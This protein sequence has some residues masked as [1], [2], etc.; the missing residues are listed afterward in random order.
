MALTFNPFTGKLDFTGSQASAAIGA[1][2]ATGPSGGPTGA[3]GSTGTAGIDGATGAT[4][5]GS[6]GATGATGP[7]ADLSGYVL[8]SGDTMTGKLVAAADLTASKL[9]IGNAIGTPGPTSVA[10]GDIWITNQNKLAWRTNGNTINAAGLSQTNTFSQPQTIGVTSNA[11]PVFSATNTGT[12]E[13]AVFTAQ[14]TS[15]AVRITQTGTGES[16]RVEDSTSPDSTAFVI[17]NLGRVGVGVTPDA[18]VALSVD[19]SGIKFGDGTIQTTASIAGATGATGFGATGATGVAGVD[20]A[21]GATGLTGNIGSTGATGLSGTDGATGATG[22]QGDVGSTG[23]TGIQGDV[24]ATGLQG[25]IGATGATGDFGATGATGATGLTGVR[26][27]TGAT[28]DIGATGLTGSGGALGYYGSF[29]DL[30]DQPLVSTT[31]EQVIS[32]GSTAEQNGV[33][34]VNGDEITFANAGTYSLTFSVQITNLANSVEK[35]TFWLKTNNV[36][37]PDSATEIDL[38]PRKAA[39]NPNR[40]VLTVNY[41]ATATAGQQV[42]IYWSGTSTDLTVETLPAGTSPVS[43]AVPSIILTA[44][45]VMYTQVGPQGATG[46][47][48]VAG[49]DGS[50]GATGIQGDAGATGA[51]GATGVGTQGSTGATGVTPA[52]IVLSDTTGLTGATQLSNIVQITQAGYDLIVTPNANTIYIIVG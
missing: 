1:T 16:F 37:Y 34:I 50:T 15:P 10:D 32:I 13:A 12:R 20:G 40:Q 5:I 28:G 9:N 8:K 7:T 49:A 19:T 29:Y 47:T 44:V 21:T 38:Q 2:G 24:G 30:T 46:A 6:V 36:D 22:L 42:Q 3:T 39:G 31:T 52:N 33:T 17:S 4:G 41:V 14:G 26:G 27:A 25:D 45:Q 18:I 35:A 48:G 51:T 43:P 11:S 23:S